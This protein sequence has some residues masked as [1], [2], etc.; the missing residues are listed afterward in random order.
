MEKPYP[1]VR[2]K[3][4]STLVKQVK[5]DNARNQIVIKIFILL[6]HS[7][8]ILHWYRTQFPSDLM[9]IMFPAVTQHLIWSWMKSLPLDS[10][11]ICQSIINLISDLFLNFSRYK[12]ENLPRSP[13]SVYMRKP[14]C[15]Y[16]GHCHYTFD[17]LC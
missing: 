2:V 12:P 3:L 5:Y 10:S 8:E 6:D 15:M 17:L 16:F 13:Q 4:P 1:T 11:R 7:G 14:I 9:H